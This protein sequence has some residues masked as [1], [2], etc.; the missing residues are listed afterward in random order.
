MNRWLFIVFTLIQLLAGPAWAQLMNDPTAAAGNTRWLG[1]QIASGRRFT[2]PSGTLFVRGT[3]TTPAVVGCGRP[4]TDGAIG[5]PIEDHQTDVAGNVTRIVQLGAGPIFRISGSGFY[6]VDPLLLKGDG[7]SAAIEFEGRTNPSTGRAVL[8][9]ITFDNWG[10]AIKALGG[11]YRGGKFVAEP[12]HAD[13]LEAFNCHAFRTPVFYR[14][15]NQQAINNTFTACGMWDHGGGPALDCIFADLE[16][17]GFVTIDRLVGSALKLTL[18]RVNWFSQNTK[19]LI[20]RDYRG[21]RL[22]YPGW[23]LTPIE[24]VETANRPHPATG[25]PVP[26]P[27]WQTAICDYQLEV[28][29]LIPDGAGATCDTSVRVPASMPRGAWKINLE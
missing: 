22:P 20:C 15:E 6:C 23:R 12:A 11:Y 2:I 10:C 26:G 27:D 9:N 8:A 16:H 25:I 29:G 13:N 18:F 3:A 17:G 7:K 21:D 19:R 1:E 24:Y 28:S 4:E 14:C 5:Y